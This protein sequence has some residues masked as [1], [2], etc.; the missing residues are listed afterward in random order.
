MNFITEVF[1]YLIDLVLVQWFGWVGFLWLLVWII[2]KLKTIKN[3]E[4][5]VKSIKWVFLEVKVE[6]LSEKSPLAMEQVFAALHAI[7]TN[8]TW[9][10]VLNGRVVLWLSCEIVSIGGRVSYIFKIPERYRN[11]LES[12]IFAQYP[13]AE[14]SEVLD[15][16]RNL[17]HFYEP[18][19]ADFDFWGTQLNKVKPNEYP[20]RIYSVFEHPEQKTFVDPVSNIIE[21][22]SNIQPHELMVSQL[23]I[24]PVNEDWKKNAIHTLDKLKGAP[25]KHGSSWFDSILFALPNLLGMIIDSF[26]A[27]EGEHVKEERPKDEPPSQM[28]HK[29]EGEKLVIAAIERM[30]TKPSF[31]IKLRI[32]YLAPKDKFNRSARIPEIVGAYRNFRDDSLNNLKPDLGHTWT[33]KPYR[34]SQKLEEPY[35]RVRILTRKRHMLHNFLD[36][37]LWRGSGNTILNTEELATIYH[38]PQ[39]PNVRVSQLERVQ[40]VKSAPPMDLPVG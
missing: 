35:L 2:Y 17:P 36:R 33:D 27:Q 14:I 32:F 13:K 22:M 39:S 1:Y 30:L 11:L 21:V 3:N 25:A 24:R 8:Y 18:D 34:I 5:Y 40:T 12:A 29:T 20:I 28:L 26:F 4:N 38:F 16:A 9:G 37:S 31:E 19:H 7:H 6:E 15:Y 10:E 23:V